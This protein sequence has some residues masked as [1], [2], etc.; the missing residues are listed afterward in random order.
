MSV[1]L[2]QRREELVALRSRL[3]AAAEAVHSDGGGSEINSS[4]SDQHIADHAS[5]TFERELDEGLEENAGHVVREIDVALRMI[6]E[7]T[8]GTCS[9]CGKEIPED[10][11]AAI[12]YATLCVEDKRRLEQT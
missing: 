12:P 2:A 8:Y 3:V 4:A 7:G 11:L 1:D 10:R 6:D 9:R 5:D